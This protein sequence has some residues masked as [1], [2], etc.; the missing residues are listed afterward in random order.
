MLHTTDG[1]TGDFSDI[2]FSGAASQVDFLLPAGTVSAD[3][4]DYNIGLALAWNAGTTR[5]NGIFTLATAAGSFDVDV[6]LADQ[7]ASTTG[8]NGRDLTKNGAGTLTLSALNTYTGLTTVNGGTL[9]MGIAN[10]IASSSAVAVNTGA[11]LAF[12]DLNQTLNNLGGAGAINL[13]TAAGT[14][15]TAN[16]TT[17]TT[18]A[19][20][21]GGASSLTKIGTGTLTLAGSN[22]YA[23]GTTIGDGT[24]RA[25]QG[26]VF[27]S[28]AVTNNAALRLDFATDSTLANTLAGAGSLTKTGLGI[29]TITATGSQGDIAVNAGTLRF[30]QTGA[31]HAASL[32]T[33]DGAATTVD[34]AAQL[35]VTGAFT[36]SANATL[37]VA[38][39]ANE[40]VISAGSA[41]VAGTLNITGFS[42]SV[43]QTASALTGTRFTILR[44]TGG[45]TGDFSAVNLS[46]SASAVDYILVGAQKSTD[47]L[48]YIAGFGLTWR[49]DTTRSNG[50]FT[51]AG[52]SDN[53]NVD[54]VLA[55]QA[56]SATGWNGR[57]LTKNG[58]GTLTLSALN[59]YTG[60]T[61]VNGGTLSMG[62][63]NAIA[64][65]SAVAVN[66][67]ATLAFNDL[68]QTLNNLSGAGTIS[69]GTAGATVLTASST[70][71]STFA[72]T[73]GGAG[74]LIKT[75]AGT[76]TLT[77]SSSYAGSTTIA[78][79]ALV[80]H[81]DSFGPGDILNHGA[82]VIDAPTTATMRQAISG[83]GFLVKSGSGMLELTGTSDLSGPTFVNDGRL[84][85]NGF[86]GN[87]AVTLATG[88]AI[89]GIGT[90]GA[91]H[92]NAATVEPGNSIGTLH[93]NGA[94]TQGDGGRYIAEVSPESDTSS[95]R[96]EVQGKATLAPGAVLVPT[97]TAP[98]G[99][100]INARYLVL[101][102]TE[103]ITGTYTMADDGRGSFYLL[104]DE[105]DGYNV[106][107]KTRMYRSF[108]SAAITPNQIATAGALESLP[109][110]NSLR[111]AVGRLNTDAE[112]RTA[113]DMLSGEIHASVKS[114][115]LTDS[116]Y[117]R[118]TA[119]DR[120]R[121]NRCLPASGEH[122]ATMQDVAMP[123]ANGND[124]AALDARPQA[125]ARTFGT[126]D[127][128]NG[129]GNAARMTQNMFGFIAGADATVAPGWR[130][131][132]LAGYSHGRQ[133]AGDRNSSANTDNYHL[134]L[135]SGTSWRNLGI[136]LGASASWHEI[137][138]T[139]SPAFTGFQDQLKSNYGARTLQA[140]TDVGYRFAL[141]KMDMEPFANA[142]FVNLHGDSFNEGSNAAA[143]SA[144]TANDNLTVTTLG[145]RSALSMKT[146]AGHAWSVTLM[147]GWQHTFGNDFPLRTMRF[148][149]STPFTVAGV[150]IAREAAVVEGGA[151]VR[152][153]NRTWLG[154][155]YSGRF[156]AHASSQT[157]QGKLAIRW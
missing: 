55:D 141:G 15:L 77:G 43:P 98:R 67:G 110:G 113:F 46:G 10:A 133:S 112:A 57:D 125:W 7:A 114:A 120:L 137:D 95:D 61:N 2:S 65:S 39:D 51:L 148:A 52:A 58:S 8:W 26:A 87:S 152:I 109:E 143:L 48:E 107:L 100:S 88:T 27:G 129:D 44:T 147:A 156:G 25:T 130:A 66:T 50:I 132:A 85:V 140:F 53:F 99:F 96:I 78:S 62:V 16:S 9:S 92:I 30:G 40:P 41:T 59:T 124:C 149:G 79:G 118:D 128:I 32:N 64:S 83:T 18:F 102:A 138:T 111:D 49:A 127:R 103:G 70:T 93:V 150:P 12:N 31:F 81:A 29:A 73:I 115:L 17:D 106:Y 117:L 126:Y 11:T 82:L 154:F 131:G 4:R 101:S 42:A 3:S 80:G 56:A 38:L 155:S 71:D 22:S 97:R 84:A 136:R 139:R 47:N 89:Q 119:T 5:S 63:A 135:Y 35:N 105:Y 54:V 91:L 145:L 23:G 36:K 151:N 121:Q 37:N 13:G 108:V 123:Q 74:S 69:L 76:L 20:T 21:I 68:N 153:G 116:R 24:L 142:A 75:G 6:V 19:G 144:D 146:Q 1:I 157:I 34:G 122:I 45:I 104:Q 60:A 134:G 28:G 14:M 94:Y 90:V 72:G 33:A 86:L